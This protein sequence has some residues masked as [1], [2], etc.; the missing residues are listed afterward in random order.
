MTSMLHC[1]F[2]CS[3]TLRA[4]GCNAVRQQFAAIVQETLK[5][6]DVPVIEIGDIP[7]FERVGFISCYFALILVAVAI[8][9]LVIIPLARIAAVAAPRA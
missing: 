2:E 5:D 7:K 4:N 8:A 1:G 9:V 6:A 3:L